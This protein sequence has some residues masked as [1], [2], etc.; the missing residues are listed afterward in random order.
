[1][2]NKQ[3]KPSLANQWFG[4]LPDS[5]ASAGLDAVHDRMLATTNRV[6][7]LWSESF[8]AV[9]SHH[10]TMVSSEISRSAANLH[11][12]SRSR[13]IQDML[14]VQANALRDSVI[15]NTALIRETTEIAAREGAHL[16]DLWLEGLRPPASEHAPAAPTIERVPEKSAA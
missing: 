4:W 7:K 16:L 11:E 14:E 12:V 2:S 6:A 13:S 9:L 15:A 1:M 3:A 5:G 10:L 8:Q